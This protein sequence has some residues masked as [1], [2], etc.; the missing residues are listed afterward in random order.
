MRFHR[1]SHQAPSISIVRGLEGEQNIFYLRTT[2]ITIFC[3]SVTMRHLI[4]NEVR[5]MFTVSC[6]HNTHAMRET[7]GIHS[8]AHCKQINFDAKIIASIFFIEWQMLAQRRGFLKCQYKTMP[9]SY[10]KYLLSFQ[11]Q[12]RLIIHITLL[13]S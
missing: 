7:I 12:Q 5:T 8:K 4:I 2:I 3:M 6:K 13:D 11:Q 9:N 1:I 10:V